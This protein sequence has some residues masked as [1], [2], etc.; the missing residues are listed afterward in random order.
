MHAPLKFAHRPQPSPNGFPL[1]DRFCRI[2]PVPVIAITLTAWR[3]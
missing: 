1:G 3:S 2:E